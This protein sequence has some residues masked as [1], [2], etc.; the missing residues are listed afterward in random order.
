MDGCVCAH[1][2][3]EDARAAIA[4]L[5]PMADRLR[6]MPFLEG[7]P[8]S[9]H[10]IVFP[11]A[12]AT[13]RPVEMIVLRRP[14][15]PRLHYAQAGSFWEPPR[16]VGDEMR[17]LAIRTGEYLRATTGYRGAFTIDGVW[18]DAGFRPTE[19]NA[20]YGAAL[21]FL[22]R[23]IPG[24]W[25][26]FLCQCVVEGLELDYRPRQ[27]EELVLRGSREHRAA[28]GMAHTTEVLSESRTLRLALEG[29]TWRTVEDGEAPADATAAVGPGPTGGIVIVRLDPERTPV[30]PSSA[31][32]VAGLLQ[33]LDGMLGLGVG[34][35][36]PA[37][38]PSGSS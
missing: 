5:A 16:A 15:G 34:T 19:L 14:D 11:D 12:M 29:D 35:L 1:R 10:G 20:R 31:P 27:L 3:R 8:C 37:P 17:G 2:V 7:L 36:L 30:G 22:T 28:G 18:T 4:D 9:I 23:S 38:D 24:L 13:F 25:L 26:Y 33:A 21:N 6:V 32:R